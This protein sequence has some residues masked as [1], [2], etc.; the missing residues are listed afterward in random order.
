[1]KFTVYGLQFTVR[2]Q[3]PVNSDHWLPLTD[4]IPFTVYC[5][6]FTE[7]VCKEAVL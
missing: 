4:N 2:L 5:S 7:A 1:M 6:L 3:L